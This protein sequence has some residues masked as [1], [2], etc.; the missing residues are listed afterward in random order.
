MNALWPTTPNCS[1][2]RHNLYEPE[3]REAKGYSKSNNK[4]I[5]PKGT[6]FR[7]LFLLKP[8]TRFAQTPEL[9][10]F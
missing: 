4:R 1:L 3:C 5:E 9:L 6:S 8:L 10:S 2:S 7:V